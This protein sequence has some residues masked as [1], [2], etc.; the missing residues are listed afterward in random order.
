MTT[1]SYKRMG[2]L[3]GQEIAANFDLNSMP[4]T[5]AQR[6]HDLINESNFFEIPVVNVVPSGPHEFAYTITIVSG[7]SIHTV[8]A[9]DS[10]MPKALRP[11]VHDLTKLAIPTDA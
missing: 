11:L 6:L 7:N 2:G 4:I 10:L 9:T 8:H 1:I 3:L 5:D